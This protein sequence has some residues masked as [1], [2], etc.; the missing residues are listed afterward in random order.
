[1]MSEDPEPY[2]DMMAGEMMDEEAAPMM[3]AEPMMEA[4]MEA[5]E[6]EIY[7]GRVKLIDDMDLFKQSFARVVTLEEYGSYSKT[8]FDETCKYTDEKAPYC[9]QEG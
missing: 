4:D 1:M 3:E 2:M 8:S 9:G 6:R 7:I 5:A